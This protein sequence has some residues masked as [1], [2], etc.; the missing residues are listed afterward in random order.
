MNLNVATNRNLFENIQSVPT[1]KGDV[2]VLIILKFRVNKVHPIRI[3]KKKKS[4]LPIKRR[5][6]INVLFINYLLKII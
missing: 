4:K 6:M 5:M 1:K 2:Q 3:I